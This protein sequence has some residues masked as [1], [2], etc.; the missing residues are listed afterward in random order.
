MNLAKHFDREAT[1]TVLTRQYNDYKERHPKARQ[2]DIATGLAA[3]EAA[4]V[5]A[6][7][8]VQSIRLQS[9]INNI[10]EALPSLGYVMTLLRNEHAVH[11]RK[12]IFENISLR[13][14][15]GLVIAD[16]RKI[17]LRLFLSQWKYVFAVK[18]DLPKGDARYSLQFFDATGTAIQKIYLQPESNNENY[19]AILERYKSDDQI[20][21]IEYQKNTAAEPNYTADDDVDQCQLRKDWEA[22]TDVHQFFGMLKKY[23]ISRTQAFRLIGEDYA[24]AFSPDVFEKIL[25]AAAAVALPIMCFV[26]NKGGI[27]IHT[28]PVNTIKRM[29]PWLNILDPEFNLHLL[30]TGIAEAWLV[31]KNSKDGLITSLELYDNAGGQIT[32][33]FGQ[34]EEGNKENPYWTDLAQSVLTLSENE[35]PLSQVIA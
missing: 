13:G 20:S 5:D 29:S 34:R 33:F 24:Q 18:Q 15:M 17:D 1:E 14:H 32:Q 35:S 10:I 11:E 2:R 9:D 7:L 25:T 16:D 12:G 28:G 19:K 30:E 6:Q 23:N 31:R 8:G 27:Q 3:S 4:L 21:A 22:M 26:G